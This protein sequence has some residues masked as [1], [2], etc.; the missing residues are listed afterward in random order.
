MSAA[1]SRSG[2]SRTTGSTPDTTSSGRS[3]SEAS[4][5]TDSSQDESDD[6]SDDGFLA[7]AAGAA[8]AALILRLRRAEEARREANYEEDD[9]DRPTTLEEAVEWFGER[10]FLHETRFPVEQFEYLCEHLQVPATL[11]SHDQRRRSAG[12]VVVP[13]GWES[14]GQQAHISNSESPIHR[15]KRLK[16]LDGR[17]VLAMAVNRLAHPVTVKGQLTFKW[18]YRRSALTKYTLAGIEWLVDR[19]VVAILVEHITAS[20]C[21]HNRLPPLPPFTQTD[22]ATS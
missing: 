19:Y 22:G 16:K 6:E 17:L 12:C 13:F 1:S 8:I 18:G 2:G 9:E 5:D 10:Q 15:Y 21:L 14:V 4:S 20:V 7:A 11:P 3:S